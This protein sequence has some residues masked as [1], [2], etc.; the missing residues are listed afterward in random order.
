MVCVRITKSSAFKGDSEDKNSLCK[1]NSDLCTTA[2]IAFHNWHE[3][4]EFVGSMYI[5]LAKKKL[6][7]H[8]PLIQTT[9][10]FSVVLYLACLTWVGQML[11]G[12]RSFAV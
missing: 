3:I 4:S 1:Q 5:H 12:V 2:V 11:S 8:C 7:F 6:L 9:P 10:A